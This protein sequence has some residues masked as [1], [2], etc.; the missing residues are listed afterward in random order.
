[1][2]GCFGKHEEIEEPVKKTNKKQQGKKQQEKK[3]QEKKQKTVEPH[4]RQRIPQE[5]RNLVWDKYHHG[6]DRGVCYCCGVDIDRYH[7][8]WHCSHVKSD[9]KG[10]LENVE[11][12]RTCC[13]H[14]N[15]SMGDQ[16]LYAY[17][18][19]KGMQGPGV[20]NIKSYFKQNPDQVGD[21][22]TNNWKK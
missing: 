20:K 19:D 10:G 5:L 9:A 2:G 13:P 21:V 15:L 7:A 3:Q 11:N 8:G 14:C 17:M 1:M 16:N 6:Q 22:R 18:L 12:M 4:V